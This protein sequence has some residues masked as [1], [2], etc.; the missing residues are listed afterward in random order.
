MILLRK[1]LKY[2]LMNGITLLRLGQSQGE[3]I[4][5]EF[6]RFSFEKRKNIMTWSFYE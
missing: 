2:E 5:G 3:V 1:L 4:T 6:T